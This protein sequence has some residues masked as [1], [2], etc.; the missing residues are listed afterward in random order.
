M[1]SIDFSNITK[2]KLYPEFD[3]IRIYY[4]LTDEI[5]SFKNEKEYNDFLQKLNNYLIKNK[6]NNN[7]YQENR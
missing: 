2:V 1:K 3:E 6:T 4:E 5:I 7:S